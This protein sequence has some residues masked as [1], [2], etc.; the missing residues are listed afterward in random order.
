MCYE[1]NLN[2][3]RALVKRVDVTHYESIKLTRANGFAD[4][5]VKFERTSS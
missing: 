5:Q 1:Q 4:L 2:L 3:S